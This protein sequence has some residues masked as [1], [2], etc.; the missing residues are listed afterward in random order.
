MMFPVVLVPDIATIDADD[1]RFRR[2]RPAVD[3]TLVKPN[4]LFVAEIGVVTAGDL[5]QVP[6]DVRGVSGA[7]DQQNVFQQFR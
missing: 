7:A 1:D 4:R 6:A 2:Q 3:R 5:V